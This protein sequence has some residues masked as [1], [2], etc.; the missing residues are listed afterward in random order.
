MS[1]MQDFF[2]NHLN[3]NP[4]KDERYDVCVLDPDNVYEAMLEANKPLAEAWVIFAEQKNPATRSPLLDRFA[5]SGSRV[6]LVRTDNSQVRIT[7]PIEQ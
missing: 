3:P 1:I 6:A 2:E 4:T 7:F 5:G